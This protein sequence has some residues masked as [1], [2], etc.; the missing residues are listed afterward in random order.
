MIVR[1]IDLCTLGGIMYSERGKWLK[2]NETLHNEQLAKANIYLEYQF[3]YIVI[4]CS[5]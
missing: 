4:S 2:R 3:C 5:D 1:E